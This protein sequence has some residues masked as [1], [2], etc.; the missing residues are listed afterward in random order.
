MEF[1]IPDKQFVA[2]AIAK[3]LTDEVLSNS[4][5]ERN[6]EWFMYRDH[7]RMRIVVRCKNKPRDLLVYGLKWLKDN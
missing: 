1:M 7:M 6:K 2:S 4:I 3:Y 5:S